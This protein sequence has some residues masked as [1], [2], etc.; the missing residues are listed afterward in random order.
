ML[1]RII[2]IPLLVAAARKC[3]FVLLLALFSV[4]AFGLRLHDHHEHESG[5]ENCA[6][7]FCASMLNAHA[8]DHCT[9]MNHCE[10][11]HEHSPFVLCDVS[12]VVKNADAYVSRLSLSASAPRV[13][14][15]LAKASAEQQ[16]LRSSCD[17]SFLLSRASAG[18]VCPLPGLQLPLII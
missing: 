8:C 6:K 13:G 7:H 10:H 14:S 17:V 9:G 3:C 4:H 16:D 2:N 15:F 5:S 1:T 11:T 12:P 18:Y